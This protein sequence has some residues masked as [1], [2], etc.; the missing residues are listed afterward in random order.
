MVI[1]IKENTASSQSNKSDRKVNISFWVNNALKRFVDITTALLGL[2]FLSPLF[3]FLALLIKRDTSGPVFFKGKRAGLRGKPFSIL[4]FRTMYERPE[5]YQGP[6]VTGNGDPRITRIGQWLRDT[7]LNEFPQ[8]INVLRGEMSLVGP[9]PED[10]DIAATWPENARKIILSIRPG[11]TSPAS[12]LYRDEESR[13]S[14]GRV[15]DE[16]LGNILPDKLRLDQ[17]YVANHTF[18]SD[19]DII[20]WTFVTFFPAMKRVS[21]PEKRL[22]AGP[23]YRLTRRYISWFLLDTLTVLVAVGLAGLLWRSTG[24]LDLGWGVS[25]GVALAIAL[26]FGFMNSLLG[27]NRITWRQ[28]K[29]S[30]SLDLAFSSAIA[31]SVLVGINSFWPTGGFLPAGMLLITGLF[32]F[33]G[34]LIVRYRDRLITGLASR[35]LWHRRRAGSLGEQVLIIGAGEASQLA[36]WF[37]EK[38]KFASAFSITGMVDDNLFKQETLV[39][40]YPVLGTTHDL[41]EIVEEKNIGL[42]M[43]A[44]SNIQIDEKDRILRLCQQTS[45]HLVIIPDLLNLIQSHFIPQSEEVVA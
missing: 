14:S 3:I 20:L 24:P 33:L 38:S 28:A 40:G 45:V 32:A 5:S 29:L 23:V 43:Y 17:L 13:L 2:L 9:R 15:M 6:C 44:I 10:F 36:I 27:L 26:L 18:L 7:K 42:I 30:F 35:W 22:Y 39:D 21:I 8:L 11:I 31:T 25:V 12:I 1:C 41:L 16:Y 37:L 4:K 34:C 19:L